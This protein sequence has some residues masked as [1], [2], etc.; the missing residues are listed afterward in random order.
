MDVFDC[1]RYVIDVFTVRVTKKDIGLLVILY[2]IAMI[3]LK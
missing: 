3:K 1:E 2:F